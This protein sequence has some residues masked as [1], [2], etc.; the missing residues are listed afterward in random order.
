MISVEIVFA[1]ITMNATKL[2]LTNVITF[3]VNQYDLILPLYGAE[4]HEVTGCR[5]EWT[6]ETGQSGTRL[7][8]IYSSAPGML[9]ESDAGG[10][11]L[12]SKLDP[13]H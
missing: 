5:H 6:S 2:L 10:L 4:R 1:C 13:L 9:R 12:E 8:P 3:S 7:V 11:S